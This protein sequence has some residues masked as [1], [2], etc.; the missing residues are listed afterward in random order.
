MKTLMRPTESVPRHSATTPAPT[1]ERKEAFTLIELLVVIA[2]IAVL[3]A[4][5]FPAFGS[6]M[7]KGNRAR[8]AGNLKVLSGA[9]LRYAADNNYTLPALTNNP[10]H[11]G[12]YNNW[13]CVAL[14]FTDKATNAAL[15]EANAKGL[16]CMYCPSM[17]YPLYA[18]ST[19]VRWPQDVSYG[20]NGNLVGSSGAT[21]QSKRIMARITRPSEIILLADSAT[22][23]Q[24]GGNGFQINN[25]SGSGAGDP[26]KRHGGGVNVAWC[27]GHVSWE[28]P[29]S[30]TNKLWVR[31]NKSNWVP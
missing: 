12:P 26:S 27:D 10:S 14:D 24:D 30:V 8:C 13:F 18:G 17:K 31:S 16:S 21:N 1:A 7:E 23:E 4:I 9:V 29:F 6:F 22:H 2:I 3:A 25:S 19:R 11:P 28:D 5:A 20:I 15:T